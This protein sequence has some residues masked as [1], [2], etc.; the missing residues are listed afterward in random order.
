M[1]WEIEHIESDNYVKVTCDGIFSIEEHFE[2]FK[3]L[4]SSPFWKPGMNLLFDNQK[5]D[6]SQM[7]LNK[8]KMASSHY[9]RMSDQLGKG[10]VAML[11]KTT[12]G[13]GI[14]RQFQ[15]LSEDKIQSE[16]KVF[17]D[18]KTAIDWLVAASS[19]QTSN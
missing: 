14:G 9:Q 16:T 6:F 12:L 8:V 17:T 1:N 19:V 18:K 15:I 3:K 2:W 11:M 4:V 7:D 13:Y 10:R 5:F